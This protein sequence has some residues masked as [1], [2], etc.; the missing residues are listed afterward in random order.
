MD[1]VQKLIKGQ[2]NNKKLSRQQRIDDLAL[3]T[4]QDFRY[5]TRML[6][7]KYNEEHIKRQVKFRKEMVEMKRTSKEI[8]AS[9]PN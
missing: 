1:L 2:Y 5:I 7:K 9:V 8:I 3:L 4:E 6:T